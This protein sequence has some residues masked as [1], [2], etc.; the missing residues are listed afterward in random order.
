MATKAPP[1]LDKQNKEVQLDLIK[2]ALGDVIAIGYDPKDIKT[3]SD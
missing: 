1:K 2:K 3:K